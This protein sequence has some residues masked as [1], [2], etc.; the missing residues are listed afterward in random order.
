MKETIIYIRER[1]TPEEALK[2][3]WSKKI[4]FGRLAVLSH[5]K[6]ELAKSGRNV[7]EG[8]LRGSRRST[9]TKKWSAMTAS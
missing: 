6:E 2:N 5:E 3:W 9:R 7:D 4:C 8:Y 1:I